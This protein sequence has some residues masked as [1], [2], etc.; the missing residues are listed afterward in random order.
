[1]RVVASFLIPFTALLHTAVAQKAATTEKKPT[2][3]NNIIRENDP[4]DKAAEAA[5]SAEFNIIEVRDSKAYTAATERT[6]VVPRPPRTQSGQP[7][8]GDVWVVFIVTPDGRVIEPFIFKSTDKRLNMVVLN[9][10]RQWHFAPA[11]LN[12]SAVSAAQG[13]QVTFEAPRARYPKA[14]AYYAPPPEYRPLR[15][16]EWAQGS[17]IFTV[18]IDPKYGFVTSVA[19]KKSTGWQSLDKEAIIALRR[20]KFRVPTQPS[21][22][23]PINFVHLH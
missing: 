12:G 15:N 21:I 16:G 13:E 6:R 8:F 9:A 1:M 22:E 23:V 10:V 7:I 17:G 5:Y 20:W 19:V 4:A 2:V 18:N 3:Y 11:R 14:F